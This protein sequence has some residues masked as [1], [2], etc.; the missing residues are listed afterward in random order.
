MFMLVLL[1]EGDP[2]GIYE[3][4]CWCECIHRYRCLLYCDDEKC[5]ETV[6]EHRS[7]KRAHGLGGGRG[8][9][10]D[11]FHLMVFYVEENSV[12]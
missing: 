8:A 1:S 6:T 7:G 9:A 2:G 5:L 10:H 4:L 11:G 12:I 3:L